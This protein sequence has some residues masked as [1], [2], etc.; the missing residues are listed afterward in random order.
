MDVFVETLKVLAFKQAQHILHSAVAKPTVE[1]AIQQCSR[2]VRNIDDKAIHG[3][4]KTLQRLL[5]GKVKVGSPP[6]HQHPLRAC[7][8]T[9]RRSYHR[10]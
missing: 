6:A 2:L 5:D 4:L 3:E 1:Y 8:L 7:R 10:L 9:Q